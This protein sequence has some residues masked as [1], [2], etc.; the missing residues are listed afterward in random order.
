MK[1]E[2]SGE[3][4]KAELKNKDG[5]GTQIRLS[6]LTSWRTK[7]AEKNQRREKADR[8][9]TDKKRTGA[10]LILVGIGLPIVLWFFFGEAAWRGSQSSHPA[11]L[12]ITD[13]VEIEFKYV[14]G[15]AALI[16]FWGVG[17]ILSFFFPKKG[18]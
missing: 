10:F 8:M 4:T 2:Q 3:N 13:D 6:Q 5:S 11:L 1:N 14:L 9:K 18:R 7:H 12:S 17:L 15:T 16:V